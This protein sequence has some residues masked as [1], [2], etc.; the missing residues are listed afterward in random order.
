VDRPRMIHYELHN[1]CDRIERCLFLMVCRQESAAKTT[2][3]PSLS[4]VV[5]ADGGESSFA[6]SFE[7][8]EGR[9]GY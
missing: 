6:E 8:E 4:I 2:A 5:M 7:G 1:M 9:P 3:Q